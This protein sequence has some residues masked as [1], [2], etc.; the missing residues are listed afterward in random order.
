MYVFILVYFVCIW[1]GEWGSENW[2]EN[3]RGSQT[4]RHTFEQR[5]INL[6]KS[7]NVK[8]ISHAVVSDFLQPL[9]LT[10]QR[11]RVLRFA[12][13]ESLNH[14]PLFC[15][16]MDCSLSG[17]SAHGISLA[18]ILGSHFPLQGILP[19]QELNLSQ[20]CLLHCQTDSLPL[21][22]Q[23]TPWNSGYD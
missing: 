9:G 4:W 7:D 14:A 6:W 5:T 16:P 8:C 17:P 23:G 12:A 21:S 13:V 18:R 22:H 3:P 1:G 10:M 11:N 2:N 20:L 19:T 15:D